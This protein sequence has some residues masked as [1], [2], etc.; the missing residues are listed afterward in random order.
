MSEEERA[1]RNPVSPGL[2]GGHTDDACSLA[3]LLR[4]AT[5]LVL[6]TSGSCGISHQHSLPS[7]HAWWEG[8]A[9]FQ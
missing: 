3:P 1:F 6:S 5:L 9:T 7:Q 8:P 4:S 2:K